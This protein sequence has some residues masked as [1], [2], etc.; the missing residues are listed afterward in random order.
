MMMVPRLLM[1]M[2]CG[3]L[4][5]MTSLASADLVEKKMKA[6]KGEP[7]Y[8]VTQSLQL[9][10]KGKIDTWKE[11]WCD[12]KSACSGNGNRARIMLNIAKKKITKKCVKKN[13]VYV[14]QITEK[15]NGKWMIITRCGKK[16]TVTFM[17]QKRDGKWKV[18]GLS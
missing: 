18:R 17:L 7:L 16:R 12:K 8:A 9:I 10:A 6:E 1:M 14:K 4:L 13:R 5:C 3:V 15:R 11:K 2:M